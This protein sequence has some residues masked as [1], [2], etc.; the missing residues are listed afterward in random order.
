MA[1]KINPSEEYEPIGM[2][3]LSKEKF[4]KAFQ[5]KVEEILE[6]G[7][8]ETKEEAERLVSEMDFELEVYYEKHFG[9]FAV[10]SEAVESGEI[11]SPYTTEKGEE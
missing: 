9:L 2:I 6:E 7:M 11:F 10:E 8:C 4:P 3:R 5:A 1:F